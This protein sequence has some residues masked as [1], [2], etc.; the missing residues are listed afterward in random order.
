[1]QYLTC[2]QA[3]SCKRARW[4]PTFAQASTFVALQGLCSGLGGAAQLLIHVTMQSSAHATQG[5]TIQAQ[6]RL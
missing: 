5:A 3:C 2:R 4:G 1:M 6:A